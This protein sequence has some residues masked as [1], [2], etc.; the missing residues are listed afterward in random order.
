VAV[1]TPFDAREIL[2]RL[3]AYTF[4]PCPLDAVQLCQ[5]RGDGDGFYTTVEAVA[6]SARA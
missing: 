4:G 6:M 3:A 2:N 1:R 5:M